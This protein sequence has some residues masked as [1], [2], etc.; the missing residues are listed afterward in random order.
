MEGVLLTAALLACP[1]G[2]GLMVWFMARGQKK[3]A[4]E[5]SRSV[6]DLRAEQQRLDT[7]IAD[8]EGR[9]GV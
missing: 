8:A 7:A 5:D 1:V 6:P 3:P 2:M 9:R 4:A